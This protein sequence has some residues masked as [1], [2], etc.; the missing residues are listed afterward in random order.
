MQRNKSKAMVDP[1]CA[2]CGMNLNVRVNVLF[3]AVIMAILLVPSVLGST[4]D[5]SPLPSAV[6]ST[7]IG[8]NFTL[9][10]KPTNLAQYDHSSGTWYSS[11]K[12]EV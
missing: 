7:V 8:G 10:G 1:K 4:H 3:L 12:P 11:L 6:P 2:Y 9:N 5:Q